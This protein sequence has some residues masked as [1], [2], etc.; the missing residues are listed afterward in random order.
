MKKLM[1]L[2]FCVVLLGIGK[3]VYAQSACGGMIEY[4]AD[5]SGNSRKWSISCCPKGTTPK[6]TAYSKIKGKDDVDAIA[7][8]CERDNGETFWV[9]SDDFQRQPKKLECQSGEVMVGIYSKDEMGHDG[10]SDKLDGLTPICLKQGGGSTYRVANRDIQGGREGREQT[11][12]PPRKIVGLAYKAK[13]KG[14]SDQTDC[15][16]IITK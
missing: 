4:V 11:I 1:A 7:M 3:M 2:S 13:E 6:G 16:T 5:C 15:V 9:T 14:S 10:R 8:M 12:S